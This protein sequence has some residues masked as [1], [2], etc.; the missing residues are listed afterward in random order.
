MEPQSP[1]NNTKNR[2]MAKIVGIGNA[3]V[4]VIV[5][6][7]NEDLLKQ[8][9]LEKGGMEMI[10]SE[11]KRTIHDRIK[12]M[13]QAS[14]PKRANPWMVLEVEPPVAEACGI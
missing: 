10:D 11:R 8:F 2:N 13:P 7:E 3:L 9:A 4:D 1:H 12:T 5:K 6:L 14:M